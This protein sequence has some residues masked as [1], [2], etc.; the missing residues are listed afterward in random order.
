M[1]FISELLFLVESNTYVPS[2]LIIIL[3]F[4]SLLFGFICGSKIS[5]GMIALSSFNFLIGFF[6]KVNF[7]LP[8]KILE[9]L[10][11]FFVLTPVLFRNCC[12]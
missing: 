4:A 9:L 5:L 8:K 6:Y 3:I 10:L 7:M 1:K 12:G 11:M 2:S